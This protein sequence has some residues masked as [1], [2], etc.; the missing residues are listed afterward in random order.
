MVETVI[1]FTIQNGEIQRVIDAMKGL[2]PIPQINT[3]EEGLLPV[4][5]NEFTDA[6]WAKES[7]RRHIINQVRR[8]EQKEAE[9]VVSVQSDDSLIS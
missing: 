7:L 6:Q 1:T 4:M 3:A 8:F 5:E 2:Y 9:K